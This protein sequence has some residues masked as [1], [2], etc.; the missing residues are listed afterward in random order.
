M[1]ASSAFTARAFFYD[2]TLQA[3]VLLASDPWTSAPVGW[4]ADLATNTFTPI[5]TANIYGLSLPSGGLASFDPVLGKLVVVDLDSWTWEAGAAATPAH[6]FHVDTSRANGPDPSAC[7]DRASCPIQQI[8]VRW[9]G[10]GTAPTQNGAMLQAWTGDWL[11]AQGTT[12]T[13]AA[14]AAI[15]WSWTPASTFPASGLFHGSAR[16]LSFALVPRATTSAAGAAQ[17]AT[18]AV[19]VTVRYRRP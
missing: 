7:V 1:T 13:A 10:G 9:V 11:D 2:S 5:A 15:T 17:V 12:A 8:D 3:P 19:E 6:L 14:P 16:E 4:V 18:D